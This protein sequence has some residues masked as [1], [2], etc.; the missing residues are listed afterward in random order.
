MRLVVRTMSFQLSNPLPS[1]PLQ[2][3]EDVVVQIFYNVHSCDPDRSDRLIKVSRWSR[4]WE[5]KEITL[6]ASLCCQTANLSCLLSMIQ[7]VKIWETQ[8][9]FSEKALQVRRVPVLDCSQWCVFVSPV[10]NTSDSNWKWR[11]FGKLCF[12][13]VLIVLLLFICCNYPQGNAKGAPSTD[14]GMCVRPSHN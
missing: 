8:N 11:S 7:V 13:V 9:Y 14:T 4:W 2:A 10:A 3:I 12:V 6:P 5:Q 1:C